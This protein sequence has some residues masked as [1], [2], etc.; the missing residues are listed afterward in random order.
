VNA[1]RSFQRLSSHQGKTIGR[2][3]L[4]A[5]ISFSAATNI[6]AAFCDSENEIGTQQADGEENNEQAGMAAKV[7]PEPQFKIDDCKN[8]VCESQATLLKKAMSSFATNSTENIKKQETLSVDQGGSPLSREEIGT[9]T[10]SLLHTLAAYYPEQPS[11]EEKQKALNF[12]EALASFYP[13]SWCKKDFQEKIKQY[14]PCVE[15]QACFSAWMCLQH[16]LVNEKLGKPL[17]DCNFQNL[18]SR[19][20]YRKP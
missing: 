16:N 13:C 7:E 17:F 8:P 3:L 4:L 5:A 18:Q 6:S 19:W 10:W 14:P 20:R 15:D 2:C 1:S 9:A 11:V 12:I